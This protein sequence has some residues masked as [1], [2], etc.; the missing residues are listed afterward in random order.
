[1]H[2][3]ITA[4]VPRPSASYPVPTGIHRP[5]TIGN[6]PNV[7]LYAG[8][9]PATNVTSMNATNS[10]TTTT[11]VNTTNTMG[12]Q[13]PPVPYVIHVNAPQKHTDPLE[14]LTNHFLKTV[15]YTSPKKF[16]MNSDPSYNCKRF[17]YFVTDLRNIFNLVTETRNMFTS[18]HTGIL[19][20]LAT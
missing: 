12:R 3:H 5:P 2:I 11:G 8:V 4:Y 16:H 19:V 10:N 14:M 17:N 1:M 20:Q 15:K 18:T 6:D 9:I 13:T 7:N